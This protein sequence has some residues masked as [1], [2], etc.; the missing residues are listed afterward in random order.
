MS[1]STAASVLFQPLK[2]GP[3][4][5]RNRVLMS[6]MTRNRSIPT[7]VPNEINLAYYK[8]RAESAGLIVTEGTLISQQGTEW[9]WAPGIWSLEQ[10]NAWKKITDAVHEQGCHIYSQLK[11]QK[12]WHVGRVAHPDAPEQIA[13]G[14]P[15]YG[16]SAISARGGKFRWIPGS[17]SHITPTPLE[18]PRKIIA[19]FKKAAVHAQQ[20]G[21]DGVELHAASGYLVNQF[22]D[23]SSNQRTDEWGGSVE[24]RCR[25]GL[26]VIQAL[27]DVWGA[28]RVGIRVTPSGGYN[29]MGMPLDETIATFNYFLSEADKFG[30]AYINL[31]RYIELTDPVIDGLKRGVP[32][33]IIATYSPVIKKSTILSNGAFTPDEAASFVSGEE[34]SLIVLNGDNLIRP[35]GGKVAGVFFGIPWISHP[36]FAKRIQFGKPLDQKPVIPLFYGHGGELEDQKKGYIDYPSAEY[37]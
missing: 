20:A 17:P 26:E 13:S 1:N 31:I 30:L 2:L 21:F 28:D 23:S 24:N 4:A 27:V 14:E 16:P 10:V 15:V 18:D 32:H 29:D 6:A 36:D 35:P 9:P 11:I 33:D 3:I 19:Q 12:L 25:F 8:Q 37:N 7:N 22:L 5:L 34:V